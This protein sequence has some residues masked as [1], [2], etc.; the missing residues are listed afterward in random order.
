MAQAYANRAVVETLEGKKLEAAR[1]FETAFKL[2]PGLRKAY[3]KFLK[4]LQ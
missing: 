4:R 2:E 3:E 1:D